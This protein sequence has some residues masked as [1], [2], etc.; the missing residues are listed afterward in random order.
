VTAAQTTRLI[1]WRHGNTDWNRTRRF[2]GQS[3]TPLNEVG[4]EQAAQAA[5]LL[6]G[7]APDAIVSSDLSRAAD[8]AAVLGDLTGLPVRHDPRLR[9]RYFGQWQGLS[10]AEI[11]ERFPAEHARWEAGAQ[12][13]GSDIESQDDLA[14]RVGEALQDAADACPGGTVVAT[15]HGGG[16]RQGI[17][18]L[19]GWPAEATR[20]LRVLGNCHWAEL[21]SGAQGW[22]LGAYNVG[23]AMR[24]ESPLSA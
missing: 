3:D 6:A 14:K 24:A 13:P 12:A 8:T 15:T 23:P 20:T 17:A 19:L 9:E 16:A 4:R 1:V 21:V 7:L 2:Q 18:W 5:R 11:A 10:L 22:R